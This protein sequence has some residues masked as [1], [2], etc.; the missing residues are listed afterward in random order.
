MY[1]SEYEKISKYLS[2]N[3]SL[4]E[5]ALFMAELD[6]SEE[7]Q[8][9]VELAAGLYNSGNREQLEKLRTTIAPKVISINPHKIRYWLGIAASIALIV[10]LAIWQLFFNEQEQLVFA[11]NDK[12]VSYTLP[13][14][15]VVTLNKNSRLVYFIDDETRVTELE[16][17]AFFEV[18][19]DKSRPFFV[20]TTNANIRVLGTS[21]LVN[22]VTENSTT[23]SV[24]TG[25][26][27]FTTKKKEGNKVLL[28]P[29]EQGKL[30]KNDNKIVKSVNLA[31]KH[32]YWKD[33]T[34]IFRKTRL[35]RVIKTLVEV[36][37]VD[38]EL[39]NEL[40]QDCK[41]SVAFENE[42]LENILEIIG[43]TFNFKVEKQQERFI[44]DGE[45]C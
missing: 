26:V 33:H 6:Q 35:E 45:T 41:I 21:F 15:S 40:L 24:E 1:S 8:R 7:L 39:K 30:Y 17:I 4:E 27:S 44:I 14:S 34:L 5:L 10:S 9:E 25:K 22:T 32:L 23:V 16:G 31:V 37:E 20:N 19:H 36:Y 12:P 38:I 2:G 18:K 42:T 11:A 28:L 3:M 29:G 13:D 43:V